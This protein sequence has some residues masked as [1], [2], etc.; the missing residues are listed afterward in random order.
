MLHSKSLQSCPTLCNAVDCS[1]PGFSFHGI[2]QARILEWVAISSSRGSSQS[3]D[4]TRISCIG[5]SVLYPSTTWEAPNHCLPVG[6]LRNSAIPWQKWVVHLHLEQS[7]S[8]FFLPGNNY[9]SLVRSWSAFCEVPI[10]IYRILKRGLLELWLN[11]M[12]NVYSFIIVILKRNWH[13]CS[14]I[15]EY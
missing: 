8:F 14:T 1:L 6:F 10:L 7:R 5:R 11:I 9:C 3:R 2:L 4:Q 15:Y 12:N 13:F